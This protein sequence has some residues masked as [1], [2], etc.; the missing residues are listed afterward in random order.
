MGFL[1]TWLAGQIIWP[2]V[3]FILGHLQWLGGLMNALGF[4]FFGAIIIFAG[5]AYE[6][7]TLI[8][9]LTIQATTQLSGLLN[10]ALGGA[11]SSV[12]SSS[13]TGDIGYYLSICNTFY[14]LDE[15]VRML[16]AMISLWVA[17]MAFRLIKMLIPFFAAP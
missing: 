1:F 12:G 13:P 14:P 7:F 5:I 6:G 9:D 4:R 17:I 2:S 3:K 15:T 10:G 8:G 11:A 16:A